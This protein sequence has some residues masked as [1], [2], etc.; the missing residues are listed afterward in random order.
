MSATDLNIIN[1]LINNKNAVV[2]VLTTQFKGKNRLS[3]KKVEKKCINPLYCPSFD[4]GIYVDICQF[5]K[6]LLKNISS[7]KLPKIIA[8]QF[9]QILNNGIKLFATVIK[10]NVTS[11]NYKLAGVL[12]IYCPRYTIDP[13]Y[14]GLYWTEQNSNWL[15]FLEA[16]TA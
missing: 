1:F 4:D 14:Y 12:S 15:T 2:Q 5:Y 3:V 11:S 8:A 6:N 13:S 9:Q 10:A 16:F 7:L